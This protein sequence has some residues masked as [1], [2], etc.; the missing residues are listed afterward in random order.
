MT[1]NF[2]NLLNSF[3]A[4]FRRKLSFYLKKSIS[5]KIILLVL[6]IYLPDSK[7]ISVLKNQRN[8]NAVGTLRRGKGNWYI[9]VIDP[10]VRFP[11]RAI[12]FVEAT[13]RGVRDTVAERV[14]KKNNDNR[15]K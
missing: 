2:T 10:R 14:D 11:K 1:S 8:L 12:L 9:E 13:V 15:N 3:H 5:S 7:Y 6:N 4:F